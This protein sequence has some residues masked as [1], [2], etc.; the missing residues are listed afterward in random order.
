MRT[1]ILC[2]ILRAGTSRG[3]LCNLADVPSDITTRDAVLLAL[4]PG[5]L[6][7]TCARRA[8]PRL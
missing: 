3:P 8:L 1:P 2:A 7:G 4:S 6:L 5:K